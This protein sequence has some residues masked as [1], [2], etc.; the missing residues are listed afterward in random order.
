MGLDMY[1]NRKVWVGEKE[2]KAVITSTDWN[3][4][5]KTT[6]FEHVTCIEQSIGYWRKANAIHQWFVENVQDGIDDCKEYEVTMEQLW[7]L[8]DLCQEVLDDRSKAPKL[9][10]T[11]E[12]CFFGSTDYDDYY[13]GDLQLTVDIIAKVGDSPHQFLEYQASW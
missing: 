12:G 4:V 8:R 5:T 2:T 11:Q 9:L 3:G 13:F 7:E 10:P 1:L 6:E